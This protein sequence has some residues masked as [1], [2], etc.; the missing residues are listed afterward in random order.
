[1]LSRQAGSCFCLSKNSHL[2]NSLKNQSEGTPTF[3]RFNLKIY[4]TVYDHYEKFYN[5]FI[6]SSGCGI[7][8]VHNYSSSSY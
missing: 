3:N 6:D 7:N 4:I 5:I 1:M 2:L 8:L